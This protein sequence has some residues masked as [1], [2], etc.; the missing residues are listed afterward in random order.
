[1]EVKTSDPKKPVQREVKT[2]ASG[3]ETIEILEGLKEGEEVVVA[4][5]DLA[6]MRERQ[7]KMKQVEQGGGFG[8]MNRG[9]PSQSR[10]SGG[11]G[12]RASGGGR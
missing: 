11:G 7:E 5:I 12:G 1:V 9:G 10:A 6:A 4:K 3:N 2:G 8:S